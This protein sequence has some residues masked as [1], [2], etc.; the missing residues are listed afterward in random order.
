MK[1]NKKIK[2]IVSSLMLA[3]FIIFDRAYAIE[4]RE[5]VH[6]ITERVDE[7]E[8]VDTNSWLE[9]SYDNVNNYKGYTFNCVFVRKYDENAVYY[10]FNKFTINNAVTDYHPILKKY[11]D[12]FD[13]C[14]DNFKLIITKLNNEIVTERDI[15]T[16]VRAAY[17]D[18]MLEA[19]ILGTDRNEPVK[20][21]P[22]FYNVFLCLGSSQIG[23]YRNVKI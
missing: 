21:A 11:L 23:A 12:R 19:D 3:T 5:V 1:L 15:L 10:K 8:K 16:E 9:V 18:Y 2:L 17:G 20:L 7:Y 6:S 13:K 14:S 4:N 22:G